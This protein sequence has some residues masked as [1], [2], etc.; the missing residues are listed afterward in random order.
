MKIDKNQQKELLNIIRADVRKSGFKIR[1]NTIYVVKQDG[2]IHCNFLVVESKKIIYQIYIKDYSYDDIFWNIMHMSENTKKGDSLR[3]CGAFKAPSILIEK[4]EVELTDQFKE[5]SGFLIEKI[6]KCSDEF[7]LNYNIDDY[8]INFEE[9]INKEIL[10][11]L[12]YIHMNC[13]D[14]AKDIAQ[15]AIANG[16][17]GGYINEGKTFFEWMILN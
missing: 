8:V 2:F 9:G 14:K 10:K 17:M 1:S 16:N 4:G 12:A 11:C 13:S 6:D 3:A 5:L 15:N 7:L